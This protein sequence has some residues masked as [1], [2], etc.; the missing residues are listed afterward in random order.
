[1]QDAPIVPKANPL[2][3]GIKMLTM[4]KLLLQ[5]AFYVLLIGSTVWF[6]I[7]N[8][9]PELIKGMQQQV[10]DSFPPDGGR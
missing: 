7:K 1:M 2:D 3:N 6:I 8:P 4:F 10:I 9:L 5:I